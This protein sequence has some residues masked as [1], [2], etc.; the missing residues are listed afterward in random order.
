MAC[1]SEIPEEPKPIMDNLI[2]DSASKE[3]ILAAAGK[4]RDSNHAALSAWSTSWSADF[5]EGKGRG[6]VI[7][8]HGRQP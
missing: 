6:K 4:P 2:I 5:V 7:F 8:L 1:V 3:L